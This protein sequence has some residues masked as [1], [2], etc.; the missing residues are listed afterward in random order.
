MSPRAPRLTGRRLERALL[1]A[2]W[3]LHHS[4]GSHFHY[5]H[6]DRP[7]RQITIPI[8]TGEIIPQKTLRSILEQ[9][10]MTLDELIE[11]L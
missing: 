1:R 9:A 10:D 5:R 8:H 2:G 3:H 11:L 4:C 7:G 6:A